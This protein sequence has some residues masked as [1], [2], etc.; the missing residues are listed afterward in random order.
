MREPR[1]LACGTE[2]VC[3]VEEAA[4]EIGVVGEAEHDGEGCSPA[5][6]E[7]LPPVVNVELLL[8]GLLAGEVE[9]PQ[10]S[11]VVE[12]PHDGRCREADLPAGW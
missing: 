7:Q 8:V 6:A 3:Y 10:I 12:V 11:A 2:V 5:V 9:E 4:T 1:S